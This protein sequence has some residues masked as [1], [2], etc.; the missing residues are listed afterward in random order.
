MSAITGIFYRDGREVCHDQMKKMND[1]LSH[2]GPDNS[3][4]WVDGP[5]GFGHQMLWTT[6]ESIHENL[7]FADDNAKITITA[8]ARIDNR[9]QLFNDL[10]IESSH[11]VSDSELILRSYQ[12][13]GED[14]PEKLLGDFAFAIWDEEKQVLFCARDHIGVKAFYYYLSDRLFLFATEIKAI[15]SLPE[16]PCELNEEDVANYI[17]SISENR[18][19]TFYK[20]ILRLPAA[21][22]MVISS[23]EKK[24]IQYW[25]LDS[26]KKLILNSDEEYQKAFLEIFQDAIECRLR[27]SFPL[28]FELSGGLDS[29]SV[30]CT[31]KKIM[32][33]SKN[34]K[35]LNTFSATFETTPE[36]DEQQ[37]I[38]TI[39]KS[40]GKLRPIWSK[41]IC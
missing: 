32:A 39:T 19:I 20:K 36:C 38:N 3:D 40:G 30:V 1:I 26:N 14:C 16:I 28:G 15:I 7:P 31:A 18:E 6:S 10:K 35:D 11:C 37:Y 34:N 5:V 41:L 23:N 13:W 9:I 27:S 21:H 17:M 4:I 22:K 8:D 29:S 24:I 25:E 12:K 33:Q 2:R